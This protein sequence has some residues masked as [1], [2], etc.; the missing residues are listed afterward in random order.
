MGHCCSYHLFF[1]VAVLPRGASLVGG[2]G[3]GFMTSCATEDHCKGRELPEIQSAGSV[4][5]LGS[6]RKVPHYILYPPQHPPEDI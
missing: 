5:P 1:I 4:V 2:Y 3:N 6:F